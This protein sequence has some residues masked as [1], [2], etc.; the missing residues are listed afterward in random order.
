[1]EES[2]SSLN[3]KKEYFDKLL[4]KLFKQKK[5]AFILN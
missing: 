3:N 1:M 2:F 4:D 5:M